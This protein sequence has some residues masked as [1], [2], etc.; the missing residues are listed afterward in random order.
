MS[1]ALGRW[2]Q[3][4]PTLFDEVGREVN[5]LMQH[6][7]DW[8]GRERGYFTPSMNVAESDK[9]YEVSVDLPGMKP[10]DFNIEFKEGQLWITGER[11][12]E[13]EE[14]G[15]TFHRVERCYGQFR[16]VI[17]LGADVD[18]E[19]VDAEYKDGV[20]HVHVPKA[21]TVLPKRIQVKG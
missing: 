21:E 2:N 19:K 14:K 18:V 20:L 3:F 1:R 16:R 11:K 13:S 5:R 8:E 17:A 10:D 4:A 9:G 15:K 7:G 12:H 6:L